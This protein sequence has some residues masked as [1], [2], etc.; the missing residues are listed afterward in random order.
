MFKLGQQVCNHRRLSMAQIWGNCIARGG[1]KVCE[2]GERKSEEDETRQW[3]GR[4]E[5]EEGKKMCEGGEKKGE[6]DETRQW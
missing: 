5:E 4:K 3:W 6:K 2:G 1:G